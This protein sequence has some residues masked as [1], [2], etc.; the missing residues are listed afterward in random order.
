MKVVIDT[1]D[2]DF[3]VLDLILFPIV[4]LIK[5]KA[6]IEHLKEK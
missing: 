5:S 6:F 1:N 4:N 2:K 3:N